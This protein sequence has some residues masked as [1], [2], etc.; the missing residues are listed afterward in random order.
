VGDE[1]AQH[2]RNAAQRHRDADRFHEDSARRWSDKGDS[3]WMELAR[4]GAAL[5]HALARLEDDIAA[6]EARSA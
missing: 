3:E 5:E 6:L 2:H 1:R 4:R